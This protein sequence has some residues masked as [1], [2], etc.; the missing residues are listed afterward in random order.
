MAPG[1][2]PNNVV[3]NVAPGAAPN[4]VVNNVAPVDAPNIIV[5][6]VAPVD[7]PNSIVN[8]VAPG[9]A[10]NNVSNAVSHHTKKRSSISRR[11]RRARSPSSSSSYTSSSYTSGSTDSADEYVMQRVQRRRRT[12]KDRNETRRPNCN[13]NQNTLQGNPSKPSPQQPLNAHITTS[14]LCSAKSTSRSNTWDKAAK[15][16]VTSVYIGNV[17][18]DKTVRDIKT[19]LEYIGAPHNARVRQ[20]RK[21][22]DWSS[23]AIELSGGFSP[24][25]L[26]SNLWP[27][28][29]TVRPF[30]SN[31]STS[32]PHTP[33][34]PHQ[35]Q[36]TRSSQKKQGGHF[37]RPPMHNR[38]NKQAD[39]VPNS[40][41]AASSSK[42]VYELPVNYQLPAVPPQPAF[43]PA[44]QPAFQPA[45][46]TY[47]YPANIYAGL[48]DRSNWWS[49]VQQTYADTVRQ[50]QQQFPQTHMW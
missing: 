14:T 46:P 45:T 15:I 48:T 6:N 10:P 42:P 26:H 4:N 11:Q 21:Q 9:A 30:S 13:V 20:L 8:N 49:P 37:F 33:G 29:V 18:P 34:Q 2:A 41:A 47:H 35:H 22:T 38:G 1:A 50:P 39:R 40:T 25:I 23:F 16:K 7:A 24:D 5:N 28:G 27:H 43:Q 31:A 44:L 32:K 12:R 19:H 36:H 17:H 3:N